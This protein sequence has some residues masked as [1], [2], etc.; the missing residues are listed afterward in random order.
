M[1][2]ATSVVMASTRLSIDIYPQKCVRPIFSPPG[3]EGTTPGFE[4]SRANDQCSYVIEPA[5]LFYPA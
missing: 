3:V 5:G 1:A 2:E 4:N